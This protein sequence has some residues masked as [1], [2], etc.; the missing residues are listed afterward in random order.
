MT[1]VPENHSP[2]A[3]SDST[4]AG[5]D[6]ADAARWLS[7]VPSEPP[8]TITRIPAGPYAGFAVGDG[9]RDE[10]RAAHV[11]AMIPEEYRRPRKDV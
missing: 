9:R 2:A 1:P 5:Q 4:I 6:A 11:R 10:A 8:P 3:P 7:F